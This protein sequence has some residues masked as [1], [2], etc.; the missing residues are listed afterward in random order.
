MFTLIDTRVWWAVANF[1]ETQ[2]HHI[3]PGMHA[4]VY[5]SSRPTVTYDGIVDSVGFG[6]RPDSTLVGTFFLYR[7]TR[8]AALVKLGASGDA[9]SGT[10]PHQCARDGAIQV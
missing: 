9:L 7:I 8:C 3:L 5:L 2:L 6:V 4:D 10:R 1:R